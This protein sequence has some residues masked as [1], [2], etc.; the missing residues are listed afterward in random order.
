MKRLLILPVLL[1][2]FVKTNA[3]NGKWMYLADSRD[4]TL[5]V[6]TL[7]NDIRDTS[8]YHGRNHVLLIWTKSINKKGG[9]VGYT[10]AQYAVDTTNKQMETLSIA[11]YHADSL[12]LLKPYDD[13]PWEDVIPESNNDVL[14]LFC[15]ALHN[16]QLMHIFILNA[17]SYDLKSPP[18]K[19]PN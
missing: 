12:I 5:M 11:T 14:I 2:L 8:N 18:D 4:I 7:A 9:F 10:T 6:D 3:Q 16:Q 19:K 1:L 17:Q 13:L 15:R